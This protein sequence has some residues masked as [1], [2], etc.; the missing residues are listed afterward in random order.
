MEDVKSIYIESIDKFI[1]NLE[2]IENKRVIIDIS[3]VIKDRISD[4]LLVDYND[5][6]NNFILDCISALRSI[7]RS[8]SYIYPNPTEIDSLIST[9]E[10]VKN[11][12]RDR[13]IDIIFN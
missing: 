5:Q 10:E 3:K 11:K 2:D 12:I 9:I 13:K 6:F 8:T 1:L 7:S 4:F